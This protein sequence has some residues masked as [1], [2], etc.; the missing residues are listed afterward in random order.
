MS[1]VLIAGAG[2]AGPTLAYWL[3]RAG[4]APTLLEFAPALRTDGYMIDFWGPGYTVAERMGLLPRLREAGCSIRELRI[5]DRRFRPRVTL[6]PQVL[7]TAAG[8]RVISVPRGALVELLYRS[9]SGKVETVFGDSVQS[10]VQH[11]G[12]IDVELAR[13]ATR[14]FDLVIGADGVHSSVRHLM[15]GNGA[16]FEHDLGYR[17]A[18]FTVSGYPY[19]DEL[20]YVTRTTPGRQ[21]ARCSLR[22]GRTMFFM[23]VVSELLAK[24]DLSSVAHRKSALGDVFADIGAEAGA[25]LHALDSCDDLYF[26]VVSQARVPRWSSGRI[27]LVGDAAYGPSFLAGEGASLAMAGAYVLAGELATAVDASSAFANYER[28]LRSYVERKQRGALRMG[29][30][31]APRTWPGVWVRNGLMR[32]ATIGSLAK[33]FLGRFMRDDLPLPEQVSSDPLL[34]VGQGESRLAPSRAPT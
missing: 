33:L 10:L 11:E 25:V 31:F 7:Q 34:D 26:D 5:V 12:G 1:R 17:V 14:R 18:A 27:A 32:A 23:V 19:R 24:F 20:V 13:G 9:V 2:I 30:W 28:R 3:L 15:C 16:A 29:S 8:G 22:D 21:L 4:F 6:G